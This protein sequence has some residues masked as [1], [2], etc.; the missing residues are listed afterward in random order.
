MKTIAESIKDLP[1]FS[2]SPLF[3]ADYVKKVVPFINA[4]QE[5]IRIIIYDWRAQK[6][7][8][9]SALSL[10]NQ[11]IFNAAARGVNVRAI[12]SSETL[13][14]FLSTKGVFA[15]VLPTEKMLHTKLLILDRYHVVL[16]SH[17]FTKSA[18]TSN[19]ELSVYFIETEYENRF[20][21]YFENLWSY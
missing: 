11:A 1:A 19:H 2:V 18:F 17:N 16:G 12:V 21:S 13:K 6:E 5:E 3:G 20:I 9:V 15:K 10:F 8:E 14:D 7:P 4:V